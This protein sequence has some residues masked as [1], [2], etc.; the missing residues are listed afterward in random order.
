M[1][2]IDT[3]TLLV[4]STLVA[5]C[6][7]ADKKSWPHF[8]NELHGE[9]TVLLSV[10]FGIAFTVGAYYL[11]QLPSAYDSGDAVFFG[12]ATWL[13]GN[14]LYAATKPMRSRKDRR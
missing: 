5:V 10:V 11:G 12:I 6:T 1:A 4:L 3:N 7:E 14:G 2:T 13:L 9:R 8:F